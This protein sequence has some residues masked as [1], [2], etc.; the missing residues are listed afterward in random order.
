MKVHGRQAVNES[1]EQVLASDVGRS[2]EV[3]VPHLLHVRYTYICPQ[4]DHRLCLCLCFC[5]KCRPPPI[6]ASS[7]T[8]KANFITKL[9]LRE[10]SDSQRYRR[11]LYSD[12]H[13]VTGLDIVQE[14]DGHS[15]CVNALSW[16]SDGH[17]LAS[18][19]DDVHVNIHRYLPGDDS[20]Q[21]LKLTTSVATG[22]TQNIFS[23]KFMPHSADKTVVTAAGDGEVRVF[24]LEYAGSAGHA[25]RASALASVGR[26]RRGSQTTYLTDGNTNARVY[27][28][29]GDR[30]KRI[31][32][33]SSPHLF[34]SCSED[35]EVRQW[36]L[37]LPSS[38]YPP[39]RGFRFGHGMTFASSTASI[40][41]LP[42]VPSCLPAD[43]VLWPC[44]ER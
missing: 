26:R 14:L 1:S 27:R 34:L 12:R 35:G 19:S 37:R 36:D 41:Q 7:D 9:H 22:H 38:A 2:T 28:S 21:P 32:T 6:E 17:L 44:I 11:R 29:H 23:V 30:V 33:E 4:D 16:S 43:H 10:L 15:G 18:G 31:V 39:S 25:S 8:M 42:S 40:R 5:H 3:E 24:D 13:L 20:T